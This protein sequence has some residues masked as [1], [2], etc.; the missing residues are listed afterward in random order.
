MIELWDCPPLR[1]R[2]TEAQCQ[3]NQR[4]ERQARGK[5]EAVVL[6]LAGC[7]GCPGVRSLAGSRRPNQID[8]QAMS[9]ER[10]RRGATPDQISDASIIHERVGVGVWKGR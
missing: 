2:I 7:E 3:A 4:R 10:R 1:A 5:P 6:G 8:A 9:E